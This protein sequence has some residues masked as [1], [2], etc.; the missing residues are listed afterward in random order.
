M[1]I[2]YDPKSKLFQVDYQA[3]FGGLDSTAYASA[4]DP[5]NFAAMKNGYIEDNVL[6]SIGYSFI[7]QSDVLAG[8]I[9]CYVPLANPA[10]IA[11]SVIGYIITDTTVY[12]VVGSAPNILTINSVGAYTPAQVGASFFGHYIVIDDIQSGSPAIYWTS[13]GWHEIWGMDTVTNTIGMA[14]SYVGGGV[15]GL[16]NNQLMNFGGVS[17]LDGP[18]PNRISWSAP[19]QYSQFVPYDVGS[20]TGNYSAGFNDL[21]STSD[22]LT[23]F[24]AIGTVGYLFRNQGITQINPTGNGIQP[25]SFNHLWASELGIGSPF[26]YTIA[27]Y[28]AMVGFVSDS[29][30]YTLGLTGLVEIGQKARTYIYNLLN[31]E[32]AN[33]SAGLDLIFTFAKARIVPAILVSP[34]L[35]YVLTF[36][37]ENPD[38]S[39]PRWITIA[40]RIADGVVFD[41]GEI[42]STVNNTGLNLGFYP[43]YLLGNG[44]L[45]SGSNLKNLIYAFFNQ[46]GN[47][48]SFYR[49]AVTNTQT[50]NFNFRKEQL[51]FGYIPTINGVGFLAASVD[52]TVVGRIQISIDSGANFG[53]RT[54]PSGETLGFPDIVIPT[55]VAS[56]VLQNLYSAGVVSLQRP[57]LCVI[58]TNCVVVEAWYQGTL[59]DY[60]LIGK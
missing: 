1:A 19:G 59:S 33:F 23:G 40:I 34:E 22:I 45:S 56:T 30:I 35:F 24:A 17:Q 49:L 25:F 16:L 58:L 46:A 53:T 27:Q 57:Q 21:P 11:F 8:N 3:P 37:I 50:G 2:E 26:Y 20:G 52:S 28:G 5:H 13:G 32:G 31:L 47:R 38:F 29:G 18:V 39:N 12:R 14:T 60:A 43:T 15:L 6:K 54:G 9:I 36:S 4:I 41:F 51:K 55:G 42:A 48:V 7:Q 10:G 44:G